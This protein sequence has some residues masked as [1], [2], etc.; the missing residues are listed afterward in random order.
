MR[1]LEGR[2]RHGEKAKNCGKGDEGRVEGLK[3]RWRE[4]RAC[5]NGASEGD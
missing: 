4:D 2:K 5:Q 1:S 3:E